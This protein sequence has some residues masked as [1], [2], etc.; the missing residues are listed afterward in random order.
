MDWS[1]GIESCYYGTLVDPVTWRDRDRF[2]IT[3][4]TVSRSI[5]ELKESADVKCV[6]YNAEE[7]WVRI[8]FDATQ[9]GET[10]HIPLF[11]GLATSPKSSNNGNIET[12]TLECYSVLKPLSDI[13]LT[14]GWYA[15]AGSGA[16]VIKDL[17]SVSPAPIII[18]EN[19][20][21]LKDHI[22][23]EDGE[24]NLSMLNKILVALNWRLKITGKGEIHICPLATSPSA[25]FDIDNDCIEPTFSREYDW[26]QSPNVFIAIMNDDS[27]IAR[28]EESIE[29]R[30]REIWAEE[31]SCNL[32]AGETL[33]DYALRR[34]KERQTASQKVAYRRRFNPDLYVTDY[35]QINY[36]QLQGSFVITSQKIDIG[37]GATTTEEVRR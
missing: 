16:S 25:I 10:E 28:D 15:P 20:P 13:L 37:Y 34:L 36:R 21:V 12:S 23:A 11:T 33:Y 9:S 4:G 14:R 29:M 7:K 24:S 5:S 3:G 27:A 18:D 22:I 8:W 2:E 26:Y 6:N 32:K 31:T 17:L 30:G 19:T 35:V 1:K